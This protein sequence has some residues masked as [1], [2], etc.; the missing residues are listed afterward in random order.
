MRIWDIPVGLLC[1]NHLLGEHNELHAIWSILTNKKKGYRKH[2][3]VL[4]WIGKEN[5]LVSRHEEQVE[6]MTKRGYKH[7]S[8]L[9]V[10]SL[11][12]CEELSYSEKVQN[13]FV[14]T[15]EEQ[16]EILRNKGCSCQL[17]G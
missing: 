17:Q 14:N 10:G 15:P 11:E 4:R 5:A 13:K 1:R 6:E 9:K 7:N 8:N 2:P 3:E 12:I 16:F